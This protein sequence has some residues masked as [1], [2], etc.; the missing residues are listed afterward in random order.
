[1]NYDIR[2]TIYDV[3]FTMYDL[4][5]TMYDLRCMNYDLRFLNYR[6]FYPTTNYQLL[7]T[8]FYLKFQQSNNPTIQGSKNLK[9][10]PSIV[11]FKIC[12][13]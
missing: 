7:T 5:F 11:Y 1:M 2:C 3:G 4:R 9:I 12:F 13:S 10:Q 6:I 8:I